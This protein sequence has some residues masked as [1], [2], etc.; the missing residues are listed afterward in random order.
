MT[1]VRCRFAPAPSGAIHVGNARTALYSWLTARH[2]GGSFVLRV[3]DT[4]ASRV[5]EEA[6]HLVMD[7]LR[8]LGIEWDEGPDVGGPHAPYRQSERMDIYREHADRLI[9]DGRAYRCYCTPE[10]LEQRRQDALARGEPPGYDGRCRTRTR[11]EIAAFEA[12]GRP[13]AL[14]FW[15]PEREFVVEDLLKGEVRF[16]AG[17]LRDFVLQRSDGSP[18]YLLAAGTDDLLMGMTHII[19]GEDL[20]ASTPRQMALMEALGATTFPAYAHHPMIVGPDRQPLSKRHGSTSVEAF[21]ERGF[22]PEAL[23]N[24]LALLGWSWGEQDF[25]PTHE[26]IERFDISRVSRNPAMFDTQKLEWMNNHYIQGLEDDEL[27]A[28]CLHFLTA[29]GLSPEPVL[30]RRAMPLV[31]ERMKTLTDSVELL[32]FLFTDDV[33]PNEK[34][35]QVLAKAPDGYLGDAASALEAV[36]PW[37]GEAIAGALDALAGGAGLNRTRGWQPVRAAVTGSNVSPPLPESLELLG[38]ERTLAR[39]R[40]A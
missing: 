26:L 4:D 3:E 40:A 33:A 1:E 37:T 14:R 23:V 24:Y 25:F 39:L 21:R 36:E 16:A 22:L 2:H 38:R 12:E 17:S 6:F 10:E 5:S 31:R 27:A 18:T 11:E 9:R 30:L 13:W 19:R 8:W 28:R 32:R 29:A 7:S 35:A 20:L 15:M 34:A